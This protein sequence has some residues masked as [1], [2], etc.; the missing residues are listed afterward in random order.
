MEEIKWYIKS[1]QNGTYT[2]MEQPTDYEIEIED[3]DD[4]TY[5][6]VSTGN[7]ISNIVSKNWSKCKFV[8]SGLTEIAIINMNNKISKNPIYAKIEHPIWDGGFLETE[9][10]CSKKAIK[11]LPTR[12][13]LYEFT[14][15]LVQTKKIAG[16]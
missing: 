15:N 5:R 4:E 14:F 9:F 6:S 13:K 16:M 1:T 11:R 10:R 2:K 3:L 8:F 7:L 12:N